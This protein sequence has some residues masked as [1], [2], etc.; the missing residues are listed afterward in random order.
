MMDQSDE[1]LKLSWHFEKCARLICRR[2]ENQSIPVREFRTFFD[3]GTGSQQLRSEL[4][5]DFERLLV[6]FNQLAGTADY[7]ALRALVISSPTLQ[8]A[9]KVS[10][11]D[12]GM[13]QFT[14]VRF[15]VAYMNARQAPIFDPGVFIAVF[16]R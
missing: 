16:G 3:T 8:A 14:L 4:R 11:D 6:F 5:P 2:L 10:Q 12:E 1:R 7:I 9:F 15:L 13:L